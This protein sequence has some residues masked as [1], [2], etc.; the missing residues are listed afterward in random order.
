[1]TYKL[2][3]ILPTVSALYTVRFHKSLY[4][5]PILPSKHKEMRSG[6]RLF[7]LFCQSYIFR[8]IS[9]K[10]LYAKHINTDSSYIKNKN[11]K[12][13]KK[14]NRQIVILALSKDNIETDRNTVARESQLNPNLSF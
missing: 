7:V 4:S 1:M 3:T 6:L 13:K 12:R 2:N 14:K 10:W 5:F 11:K 9:H 8:I